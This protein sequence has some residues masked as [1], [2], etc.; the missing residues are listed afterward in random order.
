MK[1]HTIKNTF[2]RRFRSIL[3]PRKVASI[4]VAGAFLFSAAFAN[5]SIFGTNGLAPASPNPAGSGSVVATTT[6]PVSFWNSQYANS[7]FGT[8]TPNPS[9]N[10]NLGTSTNG[11]GFFS[12]TSTVVASGTIYHEDIPACGLFCEF[13]QGGLATTSTAT[14]S[15]TSYFSTN[16]SSVFGTTTGSY[17]AGTSTSTG[18]WSNQ[19]GSTDAGTSGIINYYG[20]TT[21]LPGY[22]DNANSSSLFGTTTSQ[23][24][25]P[26]TGQI[27]NTSNPNDLFYSSVPDYT[28]GF[29]GFF[30]QSAIPATTTVTGTITTNTSNPNDLF[31]SVF[32]NPADDF[33]GFFPPMQ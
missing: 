7:V 30:S 12:S 17:P 19:P 29:S 11:V 31:Y 1:P 13:T 22:F 27:F 25:G 15:G 21:S 10:I 4:G 6:T 5:A 18:F 9:G 8:S 23:T 3:Q 24:P 33:H 16:F 14:S 2:E 20:S 32:V 26:T 28:N